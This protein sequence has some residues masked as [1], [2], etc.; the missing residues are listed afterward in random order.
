VAPVEVVVPAYN[1]AGRIGPAVA[2]LADRFDVLVVDDGSTSFSGPARES[3]VPRN[4]F[5][6]ASHSSE[7]T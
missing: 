1:G 5:S 3:P 2:P 4:A 6:T 7:S